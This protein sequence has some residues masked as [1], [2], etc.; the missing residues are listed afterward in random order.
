[1]S[2]KKHWSNSD[3]FK[4]RKNEYIKSFVHRDYSIHF[5]THSFYELNIVLGGK[6][7]HLIEG[8]SREVEKGCVFVIPPG[9]RHSYINGGD[10]DVYHML[11]H[12]DFLENCFKEFLKTAGFSLFIE[13]E[14]YLRA[15]YHENMFLVLTEE[16]LAAVLSDIGM[17][18]SCSELSDGEIYLNAAAKK[19]LAQFCALISK[20]LGVEKA[21]TEGTAEVNVIAETLSFIHLN[22][23]RKLTVEELAARAGMARAT[24]IRHFE[25]VCGSSPHKYILEYR[26]KKAK[27]YMQGGNKSLTEIA[28]LCGF[29][30]AS[31]LRRCLT[32]E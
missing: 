18:D 6:G 14:P 23:D 27:V 2:E 20:R 22:F 5:H 19:L 31:H 12:L 28:L 13:I 1:M 26:L 24:F 10:L 11:I 9:V 8:M 16:E 29:Y 3:I 30:D 15:K 32:E 21:Q 17:M 7:T 25:R 4:G